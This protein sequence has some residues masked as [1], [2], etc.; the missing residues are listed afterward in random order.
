MKMFRLSALVIASIGLWAACAA[1]ADLAPAPTA[2][3]SQGTS[4]LYIVTLTANGQAMPR[5]PGSDRFTGIGFP[6]V[7][8]RRSDEPARFS[9]PDD[10]VSLSFL[11]RPDFRIGV[12]GRY[13]SGRYRS[14]D[15][16]LTG[17]RKV[18]FDIEPG[19]FIEYFPVSF[20]RARIEVR[21]G[22]RDGI[23]FTG[24]AGIDA[25]QPYNR[26]T[27]S[28]GPRLSFGDDSFVRRYFGV[29]AA[30]AVLNGRLT[31]FRPDGGLTGVGGL[32][33][34]TYSWSDRVSTTAYAQ[35][36]RLVED[37]GRSPIPRRIGSDDQF[38][39]GA[40]ISYSFAV[41][42]SRLFQ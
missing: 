31:P 2:I 1:A 22:V 6:S 17:L 40:S 36:I 10:G 33:A 38:V 34:V 42:P 19:I 28:V 13:V 14:D 30:E 16:R 35:Y 3:P 21:H 15:Q 24:N 32:G 8:F 25:I 27:F 9:A 18:D 11:E 5:F 7:T 12:V 37:A 23:G 20:L 4:D 41:S 29:T 26:F 39:F